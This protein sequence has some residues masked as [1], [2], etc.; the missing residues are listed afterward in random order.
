[1]DRPWHPSH[2]RQGSMNADQLLSNEAVISRRLR[3]TFAEGDTKQA[4]QQAT[5]E[6]S[7]QPADL[8]ASQAAQGS[9]R[10]C[11]ALLNCRG[12]HHPRL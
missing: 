2:M 3:C 8:G 1:M 12:F 11:A 5:V 10:H 9:A 7:K 6:R 4:G